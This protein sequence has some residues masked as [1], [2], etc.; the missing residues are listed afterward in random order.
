MCDLSLG[1]SSAIVDSV[2]SQ[3]SFGAMIRSTYTCNSSPTQ[4]THA[5]V[6]ER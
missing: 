2:N 5:F 4:G 1:L 6:S 3:N